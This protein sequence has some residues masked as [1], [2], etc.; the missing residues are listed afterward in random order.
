MV[1]RIWQHHFGE[2]IVRTASDFGKNGARPSHPELLDWL[3]TQFVEKGWS[4]KAM[5]RLMLTRTPITNP[6]AIPK[7]QRY[8]EIDANNDCC[9]G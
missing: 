9:G 2:G 3:A 5:H 1:N 7:R 4:M 6:P 8:A